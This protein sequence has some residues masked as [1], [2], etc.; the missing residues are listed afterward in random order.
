MFLCSD[1]AMVAHDMG[2]GQPECPARLGAVLDALASCAEVD[3]VCATRDELALVHD[4]RY[5]DALLSTRGTPVILDPD[6]RTSEGSVDAAMRAAGAAQTMVRSLIAGPDPRGFAV[7][8]PPGHH[9]LRTRAMGFCLFNNVVLAAREARRQGL[10]RVLIVDWDV[11]HGNGTEALVADDPDTLF[12][13]THQGYG[14]YPGTGQRSVHNALNAPLRPLD[15]DDEIL[16]AFRSM[17]LPAAAAFAPD[18]VLVSAG[19]DAHTRDPLGQLHVS[20]RGFAALCGLVRG[21]A[22]EH[23]HG[24]CGLVLEGGYDL[25]G[26]A[27]SSAACAEVLS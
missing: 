18:L 8:R 12:F 6:T 4:E 5:V 24:R 22:D 23:A 7:V 15:G 13:S 21:I 20:T 2:P 25:V 26:L 17:L 3:P 16:A 11:H 10:Q 1:R 27:E 14:F 19:F 9:A